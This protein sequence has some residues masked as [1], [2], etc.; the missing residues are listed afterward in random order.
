MSANVPSRDS[1][2]EKAK[3]LRKFLKEKYAVDVSQ[4]HSLELVSHL[5]GYKDWNTA[6]AI[7]KKEVGAEKLPVWIKSLGDFKKVSASSSD[8]AKLVFWNVTPIDAFLNFVKSKNLKDGTL[9][10]K[11]SLLFGSSEDGELEFQLKLEDQR[12][13]DLTGVDVT[14]SL[15]D[16]EEIIEGHQEMDEEEA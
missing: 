12:L 9:Q 14:E 1:L 7:A 8:S 15:F 5:F 3:T 10:N 4:G 11:Y 13:M 2:K 16:I 6:S